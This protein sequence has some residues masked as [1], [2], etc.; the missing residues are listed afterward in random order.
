M[1]EPDNKEQDRRA[2]NPAHH[3][4]AD[5]LVSA[6][7]RVDEASKAYF[8]ADPIHVPVD[9]ACEFGEALDAL[10]HAASYPPPQ[11][12][13]VGWQDMS[14]APKDGK[15]CILAIQTED[16]CFVYSIQGAFMG[17][18]WL[19]AAN[20]KTE[21]LAWMPNVLLPDE[22]CPWTDAYKA[23]AALTTEGQP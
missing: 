7:R 6:A 18:K 11:E 14:T 3:T 9:V 13:M 5:T 1:T 4:H 19:N 2:G 17:G 10:R 23:R 22:L 15:H 20:I 16:K 12:Q 8:E 21:P